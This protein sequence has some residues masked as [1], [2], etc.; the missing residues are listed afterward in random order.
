M[1]EKSIFIN[2][3]GIWAMVGLMLSFIAAACTHTSGTEQGMKTMQHL[4]D[5]LLA[6]L[7]DGDLALR[8]GR[9]VASYMI[10]QAGVEDKTYSHCGLVQIE[11]GRPYVYH[12]ISGASRQGLVKDKAEQFFSS[13]E[14]S[15]VGVKRYDMTGEQKKVLADAI[16]EMYTYKTGF[17]MSFDIN[18]PDKLY[19]SEFVFRVMDKVKRDTTFIKKATKNGFDYIPIDALYMNGRANDI[20][21]MRFK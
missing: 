1:A 6:R 5:T 17:D 14:N 19:C 18:S 3:Y 10:S 21:Q 7:E 20:W 15:M 16:A 11:N 8:R 12:F 13:V 2:R 4:P 9:D